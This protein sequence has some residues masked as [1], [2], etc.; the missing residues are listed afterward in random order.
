MAGAMAKIKVSAV[1]L[2]LNTVVN[3]IAVTYWTTYDRRFG[4]VIGPT[5]DF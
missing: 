1:Y 4:E 2:K 3:M 5:K